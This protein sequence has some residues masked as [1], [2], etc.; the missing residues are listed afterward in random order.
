MDATQLVSQLSSL[1]RLAHATLETVDYQS[2]LLGISKDCLTNGLDLAKTATEALKN[3]QSL[4]NENE[5]TRQASSL[6]EMESL[7]Y[8]EESSQEA[9]STPSTD[10]DM[11]KVEYDDFPNEIPSVEVKEPKDDKASSHPDVSAELFD[12]FEEEEDI[13]ENMLAEIDAM[14]EAAANSSTDTIQD[15]TTSRDDED[16]TLNDLSV[17]PPSKK[18]I[19]ALKKSFGHAS[20]RPMQWKIIHSILKNRRDQCVV[21]A[22]GYGKS[23][24]YQFPSVFTG[25]VSIVISPL[26][27]LMEDQVQALKIANIKACYLGSAQKDM[28]QAKR[29]MIRG[30]Y[31]L[32]YMTPEFASVA[33][34]LI[35]EMQTKVGITLVAIDEAH[36]VSQWGHDFR[37]AYRT[38]GNLR[39][40]LPEVPFLALTATATPMVQRDICKSLRL[41]NPDV[42]C[43]SFDRPNLYLQVDLKTGDVQSDLA[44]ILVESRKFYYEFDG[45]TIIYCPTKKA[46]ES[47]GSTLK[48][49]GVKADIYHAGM[50]PD[51]R[52]E[53]HHKFVRDELQCIVATVAFGMGID[54]PDVR[55]VI[56]YGAPKDIESY[57]QEI[58]RAGRDG[59]PSNCYAFY[60][61][62][63]FTLNWHFVRE[64]RS[65][66]FQEHKSK[67]IKKIEDYVQ[68][69]QCRRKLILSH[70]QH[71]AKSALTGSR[72]CCDNCKRKLE[73]GSDSAAS[74]QPDE[75][76]LSKELHHLLS[77]I[78][79]TRGRYGLSVPIFFLRGSSS[80]RV[81]NYLF[82]HKNF[83][84][85][86]YRSEKWWKAFAYQVLHM[87]LLAEQSIAGNRFCST[88]G[89]S[90]T[91]ENWYRDMERGTNAS[92]MIEPSQE[93]RA[94]MKEKE[95]AKPTILPK[96]TPAPLTRHILPRV[97]TG[98][99]VQFMQASV[100][101]A[102][103]DIVATQ[104]PVDPKEQELQGKLYSKLMNLRNDIA[105]DIGAAPYM[106]AN[107]KNLLDL[108]VIRPA[109]INS[110]LK[111][112][113][114]AQAR[115]EK[116]GIQFID[117]IKAYCK[118]KDLE[119][120][121]FPASAPSSISE[122]PEGSQSNGSSS[123]G[124]TFLRGAKVGTLSETKRESYTLF[125]EKGMTLEDI[126]VMRGL[127]VST[128]GGHLADAIEAGY[129]VN[130]ARAGITSAVQK[131]IEQV[132][133][134][135]PINSDIS[136]LGPIKELLPQYEYHEIKLVIAILKV[137]YGMPVK[138]SA[139]SD[140]SSPS[141]SQGSNA[142][143][144]TRPGRFDSPTSSKR[145]R[146]P[147]SSP[148]PSA[149]STPSS[150]PSAVT[151]QHSIPAYMTKP[152]KEVLKR[153]QT[154]PDM[155]PTSPPAKGN[156]PPGQ[157][158]GDQSSS[159][160][161]LPSWFSGSAVKKGKNEG[162]TQEVSTK[163]KLKGNA[164]FRK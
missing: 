30:E 33:T 21:M 52:K 8:E 73:K 58:G 123:G 131:E 14:C 80:Q 34:D 57:Y 110:M 151:K 89:L 103:E 66:E 154:L 147:N 106:V 82:K 25:G 11:G 6:E 41:K 39:Q 23:L 4:L 18:Y 55:N 86:K 148:T 27:S 153:S 133:R 28:A 40:L 1:Q 160:R 142:S 94:V 74:S 139:L 144:S 36:C 121:N 22:T 107:N 96:T 12:D 93:L 112:D 65:A 20:Y 118:E 54:K 72:D 98:D 59:M 81:P 45:P 113:G 91:G 164:L 64:I 149:T 37:S 35:E 155:P 152:Q 47:V 77:A 26:I 158:K 161:K 79:A 138:V 63:D 51:R 120:D 88:V 78:D 129:P 5:R 53:N 134:N 95:R 100:G 90:R 130:F 13:D 136:A 124:C 117:A 69:S 48:N 9:T 83:G 56:H 111:I 15:S 163:K 87:S 150:K 38:L 126:A 46:T 50:N 62:G 7:N 44:N 125:H 104:K 16:E 60:S 146:F 135:P 116:F 162:G 92:F 159:K 75:L 32:V 128:I 61:R 143:Q 145:S 3:L 17:T 137:Q 97:Q 76:D 102:S 99:W 157:S 10:G 49:L 84:I 85:G 43:T 122:K 127:K 108:A 31:R 114:I 101:G 132:I 156:V 2:K 119:M 141:S 70:F 42:T 140:T 19:D 71:N 67:M 109:N 29:N 105:S 68:T 24:C 115:A